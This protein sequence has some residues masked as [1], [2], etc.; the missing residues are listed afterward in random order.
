MGLLTT[1]PQSELLNNL[2]SWCL[3]PKPPSSYM[4]SSW[5]LHPSFQPGPSL[6]TG[7]LAA[8]TPDQTPYSWAQVTQRPSPLMLPSNTGSSPQASGLGTSHHH[9]HPPKLATLPFK[10][11]R[12]SLTE[13]TLHTVK[14][15]ADAMYEYSTQLP[16]NEDTDYRR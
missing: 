15:L 8:L 1:E 16:W 2:P 13:S 3:T 4:E 5:D 7:S 12:C 9:Q 11:L 6:A 14:C 10:P